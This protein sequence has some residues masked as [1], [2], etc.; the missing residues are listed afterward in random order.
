MPPIIVS[1]VARE[2]STRG[3]VISPG[4]GQ[5]ALRRPLDGTAWSY[6]CASRG[7]LTT[8]SA[9]RPPAPR[10]TLQG[11]PAHD[12]PRVPLDP[13]RVRARPSLL[14]ECFPGQRL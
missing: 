2:E 5:P 14:P 8:T 6:R 12:L 10:P 4:I 11:Q 13:H 1:A 9:A 3:G 7:P